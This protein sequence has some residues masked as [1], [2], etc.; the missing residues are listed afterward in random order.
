[1]TEVTFREAR[2]QDCGRILAFIRGLAEYEK[3][4]DQVVADESTLREEL[5][6]KKRAEVIFPL[7]EGREAGFAL[8]FHNFSTF[9]GRGGLYLEDLFILPEYRGQG[10]GK[11]TLR[12]LARIAQERHCGRLEW[13]C[14]RWNTPA[15]D[16]YHHMGAE[17]LSDWVTLRLTGEELRRQAAIDRVTEMEAVFDQLLAG[18]DNGELKARLTEYY[19]GPLWRADFEMDGQGLLPEGLKRGVLSEDGVWN[20]FTNG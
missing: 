9:L 16:F 1:M 11:R 13:C 6:V 7:V 14:L 4:A 19:G 5:F 17:P 15:L 10:V 12:H 3:M 20:L 2:P 18:D 8:Y